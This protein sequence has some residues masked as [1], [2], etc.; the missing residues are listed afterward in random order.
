VHEPAEHLLISLG[1]ND[2]RGVALATAMGQQLARRLAGGSTAEI[3]MPISGIKPVAL[4]AFWP[5]AVKG[6]VLAGRGR[7]RLGL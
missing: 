6:A 1:C 4:H 3:D 7:D 5:L 2:R